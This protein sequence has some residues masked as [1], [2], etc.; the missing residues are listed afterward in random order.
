VLS[1]WIY[2]SLKSRWTICTL[3]SNR[4]ML[5]CQ[6]RSIRAGSS[7]IQHNKNLNGTQINVPIEKNERESWPSLVLLHWQATTGET[8]W[9][10]T[11]IEKKWG[12]RQFYSKG[13]VPWCVLLYARIRV[14][15]I[16][17]IA[18]VPPFYASILFLCPMQRIARK[19]ISGS[20]ITKSF[21]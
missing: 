6:R 7:K 12:C 21:C 19:R 2:F 1:I 16:W 18:D 14:S 13:A 10:R 8:R 9:Q 3:G 11:N 4:V 17:P 20:L 15:M 5:T